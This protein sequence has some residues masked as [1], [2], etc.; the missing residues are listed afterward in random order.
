MMPTA[1]DYTWFKHTGLTESY[2]FTMVR[3]L[4]RAEALAVGTDVISHW[5]GVDGED[6]FLWLVDGE[7]RLDFEPCSPSVGRGVTP[8]G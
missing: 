4:R 7:V 3:G 6:R 1:A 2:C 5:G 8:M